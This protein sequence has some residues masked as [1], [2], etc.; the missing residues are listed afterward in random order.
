ML[1]PAGPGGNGIAADTGVPSVPDETGYAV[2]YPGPAVPFGGFPGHAAL[3]FTLKKVW[4]ATKRNLP[5]LSIVRATGFELKQSLLVG[6][7]GMGMVVP[8]SVTKAKG[9]VGSKIKAV[10]WVPV[11][12]LLPVAVSAPLEELS[13][14]FFKLSL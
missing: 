10:G 7:G 12:T 5:S 11:L 8:T 3:P 4:T 1:L 13:V 2:M 14:P 6:V 9:L